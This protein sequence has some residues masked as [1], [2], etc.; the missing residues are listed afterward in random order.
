MGS[1]AKRSFAAA[2]K[3]L[4]EQKVSEAL[5]KFNRAIE[6]TN[7]DLLTVNRVGDAIASAGH[8]ERAVPYYSKIADQ[9]TRQGFLPKAIAIR[10][11]ILRLT[12]NHVETLVGLGDLCVRQEHS[13]EARAYYLRAADQLLET[14]DYDG[15]REVYERLVQA[16]PE[17]A[18]HL[19]RLAETRAAAGDGAG[20]AG[21]LIGL[22]QRLLVSGH[23]P[24][25]GS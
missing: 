25:D 22:G 11:K 4:K 14:K 24:G 6:Q 9:F 2:E 8:G 12:P 15:A 13:G 5:V 16:E 21:D 20:A 18:R 1:D 10:K 17:D 23:H 19:V 7:G 3:L